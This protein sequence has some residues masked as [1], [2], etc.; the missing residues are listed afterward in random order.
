MDN[1][2]FKNLYQPVIDRIAE[3]KMVGNQILSVDDFKEERETM[4]Y[5]LQSQLVSQGAIKSLE[6]SGQWH[7]D[8]QSMVSKYALLHS[9]YSTLVKEEAT[10]ARM[11]R[12]A[13]IRATFFRFLTTLGIGFG[14]MI[15]YWVAGLCNVAMPLMRIPL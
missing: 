7:N 11:D 4:L 15:V 10:I 8:L 9:R 1:H 13:H 5:N 3:F 14:V 2:K 12:R 6:R